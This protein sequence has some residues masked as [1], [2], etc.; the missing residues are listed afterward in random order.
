MG[1]HYDDEELRKTVKF[2]EVDVDVQD[3]VDD[4]ASLLAALDDWEEMPQNG[5]GPFSAPHS[6]ATR[7]ARVPVE[8]DQA[9]ATRET[10]GALICTG[11]VVSNGYIRIAAE[12]AAHLEEGEQLTVVIRRK[13][14]RST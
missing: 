5:P 3:D 10:E 8:V 2:E 14:P 6:Q 9:A 7:I 13:K 1:S 4:S 12:V 11:V